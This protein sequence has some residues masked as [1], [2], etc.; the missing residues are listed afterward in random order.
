MSS[1]PNT[2]SC[3]FQALEMYDAIDSGD[4]YV[5]PDM[6]TRA[7]WRSSLERL[8]SGNEI[9]CFGTS[10]SASMSCSSKQ[11]VLDHAP[12]CSIETGVSTGMT[13]GADVILAGVILIKIRRHRWA[14]LIPCDTIA[15]MMLFLVFL[16]SQFPKVLI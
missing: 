1:A 2:S 3:T 5:S 14:R 10:V 6:L 7:G 15:T 4:V 9:V 12:I 13:P 16:F 11:P 8:R